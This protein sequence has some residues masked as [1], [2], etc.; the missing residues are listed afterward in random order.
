[1]SEV[2]MTTMTS[3]FTATELLP[4]ALA[5][6]GAD[7]NGQVRPEGIIG[8]TIFISSFQMFNQQRNVRIL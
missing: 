7:E 5:H 4:L 2:I 6:Q 3:D 1:M 8:V